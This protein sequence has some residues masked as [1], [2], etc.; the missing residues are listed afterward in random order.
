[1]I[2]MITL[3]YLISAISYVKLYD[4]L[5]LASFFIGST[6]ALLLALTKR[7]G[8]TANRFLS[9]AI[10]VGVFQI[11][12]VGFGVPVL[13]PLLYFYVLTLTNPAYKFRKVD[14][15][16][17]CPLLAA[18]WLPAWL[19]L[20]PV[21]I[22]LHLAHRSIQNFY[23]HLQPVLMDKPRY[24]FRHLERELWQI[25]LVCLAALFNAAFFFPL[26]FMLIVM[27]ATT[28]IKPSGHVALILPITNRSDA[29]E[30]GRRLK[31]EVAANRLYE[32]A[33]LTLATLAFQMKMT[34]H[35]LSAIINVGLGKNFNDFVNEFRVREVIRKM[36]D[37]HY[38]RLT[39]LGIA[40]ES[41]FN[42]KRTFNRVF[43]EMTGKT[44]VEYKSALKEGRP[45]YQL[46]PFPRMMPVILRSKSPTNWAV[47]TPKRNIMIRNYLKIAYRQLLKQK[48]YAVVKIGGFALGIA[49]CLL[50]GLYIRNETSFDR[51]Y[52]GADHIFRVVGDGE[53]SRGL[54]WPAPMSKAIQKDFPE[55]EFAGR[56]RLLNSYLGHAEL[57]PANEPQNTYEQ[58]I[59][60]IDQSFFNAFKLPIVYGD[61]PTAL[62]EPYTM[63]ISKTIADKYY[64][65]QNPV[66]KVMYID[67]DR[68]HPYRIG[69]VMAD[70]PANSHLHPFKFFITLSWMEFGANEQNDWRWYNYIQYIKLKA[71][72]NVA[73]FEK[74]LNTDLRKNYWMPEAR[75]GGAQD[76]KR[77]AEKFHVYLQ[78]VP[79]I[80]LYSY[81]FS[82][83][84]TNGDIR[85]VWLFGAIALFILIIACINFINLSTARSAGRAKEVGL[86]KVVGSHRS[87]LIAQFLTESLIYSFIS[88]ILGVILAC[89]LLPYF[90][91]MAA[92]S[93]TMPWLEW[94]FVPVILLA[95]LVVG[96]LAG[97]YPAFYLS[98]FRPGQVLKG[99]ISTGSKSPTLRNGL[100]VF[101][102]AASIILIISTVVIYNQMHFILNRKAGF[103]KDQVMVLQG[104]N[105][106]GEQNNKNFKAE[107]TKIAAVRSASI[108]D[109]LPIS[110]TARNGNAFFKEG[111]DKLDPAVIGQFWQVD[112]TYLQTLGIKLVEGRNFSYNMADDTAGKTIII[113]QTM[114]RS[115]GLKNPVGARVYDFGLYTVIGVVQD[116]NFES[117]R[118]EISPMAMHFGISN[119]IM[120]IKLRGGDVQNAITNVTSL[121]KKY[122]PNQPIRYTFLDEDFANMYAD[123]TRTG[124]IFTSFA[125]LAIIIACL[126]LFALSAFLAE[127]RSK[128]IGIRKILGASVQGITTLLSVDFIKLVLLAI[129]IASPIAWWAMHQWL[130]DFAFRVTIS[131][132][133]FVLAGL[134]AVLIALVTV[135]FQSIKAALANPVKSIRS[136]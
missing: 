15:M 101:Q 90:N 8:Q 16:H 123:I 20:L 29:K 64:R 84:L 43:K 122:S 82:D 104:T 59:I 78:Q 26:A 112:D 17:F 58:G 19:S 115:L 86:R 21:F 105:T 11:N 4:L 41:G 118:G 14:C 114:A 110:G 10:I 60:Y 76:P 92:R 109:Y 13:G 96:T 72:T 77:E 71:G 31:E 24:A 27:A 55:V 102:F 116:F 47:E 135:S 98:G 42:S 35:E 108:S 12:G 22:Y 32:D 61:G 134:G 46:A 129:L 37:E 30:K 127:Q 94:W 1:M 2:I 34:T 50:I 74:K 44:P 33:D 23:D 48:M 103:D 25:A 121:W 49:A 136:E 53:M 38:D 119:A 87:G 75:K 7:P 45:S 107:L 52:P 67:D 9:L 85:F 70:I 93:L 100:V 132:W 6:I 73:E 88:F 36:Q 106:L 40:L 54:A 113:N 28:I 69:A 91:S 133:M 63:V 130:Q 51:F 5:P 89:L 65:G 39:L 126:G 68:S 57:R 124:K 125:I 66:G 120:T 128:E 3:S 83:G 131:W 117:M 81:D 111:R 97:L 62:K 56:M 18:Y 79:D 95:T 99:T 80:N